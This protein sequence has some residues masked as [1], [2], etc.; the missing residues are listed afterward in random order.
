MKPEE[1]LS[2]MLATGHVPHA[3]LF[4]GGKLEKMESQALQFAA[5]LVDSD[6]TS[7]PDLHIF[8]PE[9]KAEMHAIQ[10]LR[11]MM[12]QA[13]LVPY[14][15]KRQVFLIFEAEKMLPPSSHALLKTLEDPPGHSI[16]IL[17]TVYPERILPTIH[18]RCQDVEFSKGEEQ[19]R[20]HLLSWF[21]KRGPLDEIKEEEADLFF[22][23]LMLW[24]RDRL[25]LEIPG[26]ERYLSF[27][28]QKESVANTPLISLEKIEKSIGKAKLALDRSMKF[29]PVLEMLFL[30][31]RNFEGF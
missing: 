31:L 6:K 14:Q 15:S 28:Q 23:T 5:K 4:S 27:P 8:R 11:Q 1:R 26:G 19:N 10:T 16:F 24:N 21:E 25:L 3:L 12:Q 20:E 29:H 17:L 30:Q 13:S 2:Q 7:H 22:E 9:G 18:S